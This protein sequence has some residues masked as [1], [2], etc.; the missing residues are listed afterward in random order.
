MGPH[1]LF[2]GAA[3]IQAA[4][5]VILWIFAPPGGDVAANWHAHE[6]LF[7]YVP[8]VVAGFLFSKVSRATSL[9]VLVLWAA[10]RV[11]WLFPVSP[12]VAAGLSIS[13]TAAIMGISAHSFLRGAKQASNFVF[14]CLLCLLLFC[15]I[16]SQMHVFGLAEG[17]SHGALLLALYVIVTLIL[18]MGGRIA[19]AAASGLNQRAGGARIAPRL[20]L[21]RLTPVLVG[22]VAVTAAADVL[23]ILLTACAWLAAG[24][25]CRRLLDWLP[26][27]RLAGPDLW[28]LIASQVFIAAGL[29]GTGLLPFNLGLSATAPLHLITVGGIGIA[30]VT[31]MLKTAAQRE[32]RAPD[33]YIVAATVLLLC[34]AAVSRAMAERIGPAAYGFAATAWCAAM[35]CCLARMLTRSSVIR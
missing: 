28:G 16:L 19:G 17:V 27:M 22:G 26:A 14:P 25:I 21:E 1:R 23:P 5:S 10:A 8:A 20:G 13:A 9:L 7:G 2:F 32:R 34:I 24:V 11:A 33:R 4:L 6:L 18:I 29:A 3:A 30:T 31:M 15:D 35:L 12:L